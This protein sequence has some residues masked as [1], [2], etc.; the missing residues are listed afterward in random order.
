VTLRRPESEKARTQSFSDLSP[1]QKRLHI[2]VDKTENIENQLTEFRAKEQ[3][4]WDKTI[5]IHP[6]EENAFRQFEKDVPNVAESDS[7]GHQSQAMS[8]KAEMP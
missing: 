7:F 5:Q 6:K 8:Q 2:T 1:F 4:F 3:S